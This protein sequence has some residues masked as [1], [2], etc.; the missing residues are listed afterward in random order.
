L[1]PENR[2]FERKEMLQV[3]FYDPRTDKLVDPDGFGGGME[4]AREAALS[5]TMLWSSG[6]HCLP[7]PYWVVWNHAEDVLSVFVLDEKRVLKD[8]TF[9][10]IQELVNRLPDIG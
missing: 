7:A 9:D 8:R 1:R 3:A 5:L 10:R 2:I 4:E 6:D